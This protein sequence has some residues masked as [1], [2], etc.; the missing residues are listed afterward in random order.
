MNDSLR[1]CV[2]P[3]GPDE[4]STIQ[5]ACTDSRHR[6][7]A[8]F[9]GRSDRLIDGRVTVLDEVFELLVERGQ[10]LLEPAADHPAR[11]FVLRADGAVQDVEVDHVGHQCE[12]HA[13]KL[14]T[15]HD[16]PGSDMFA[17]PPRRY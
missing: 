14:P 7:V 13:R 17:E 15:A 10:A 12:T 3:S 8:Y 1:I 16:I 6:P 2:I 9:H 11:L 4:F 5:S